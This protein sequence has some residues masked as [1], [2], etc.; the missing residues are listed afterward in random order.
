MGSSALVT[1]QYIPQ[2]HLMCGCVLLGYLQCITGA[3]GRFRIGWTTELFPREYLLRLMAEVRRLLCA[4]NDAALQVA[5]QRKFVE[6]VEA[7]KLNDQMLPLLEHL[8]S[9]TKALLPSHSLLLCPCYSFPLPLILLPGSASLS[10]SPC[11]PLTG[12]C[13]CSWQNPSVCYECWASCRLPP[14][15]ILS[16]ALS[17]GALHTL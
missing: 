12:C 1:Q 8:K 14:P 17:T 4:I 15:Q 9:Q 3:V 2:Q 16:A 13:C 5:V 11:L 6:I 10:L 7:L